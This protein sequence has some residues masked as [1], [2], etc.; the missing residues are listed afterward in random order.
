MT[1][2]LLT[3]AHKELGLE[4]TPGQAEMLESFEVGGHSTAVWQCGRRGGKST[5]ADVLALFDVY[6]RDDLRQHLR[7]GEP[8]I[9]AVI[10]PRLEQ[11]QDHIRSC[12]GLVRGNPRLQRLLVSETADELVFSNG[13]KIVAYPCSNRTI[14]GAAWSSVILDE[15]AYFQDSTDGPQAGQRV[16]EAAVPALAQFGDGGWL[17]AL[18]TPRWRSGAFHA[19]V[20]RASSGDFAD[21]HYRHLSTEEMNP[22]ISVDWLAKQRLEDPDLFAREFL[23]EFV[24]GLGSY[25]TSEDVLGCVREGGNLPPVDDVRYVGALDPA[26]SHDAFALSIGHRDV[27]T[28]SAIIDG[29]WSWTRGGHEATLDAIAE[30]ADAYGVSRLRTDQHAAVPVREGLGQRG[31]DTDYRPWSNESKMTAFSRLKVSV[32]TRAVSLPDNPVLVAELLSL[33]ARPTP[34]GMTRIAAA[35]GGHDDRAIVVAAVVDLLAVREGAVIVGPWVGERANDGIDGD[36]TRWI[37]K[38]AIRD[39][40]TPVEADPSAKTGGKPRTITPLPW[41]GTA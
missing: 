39:A 28:G 16:L 5:L 20:Q 15:L 10:S 30:L 26:Y 24:D 19:L 14:R 18:S 21:Y 29:V 32:N 31:L 2:Q 35:P 12:A 4:L 3:F 22:R 33:E 37:S 38:A 8:R 1:S 7:P 41:T 17:I 6:L 27:A 13:S 34:G 23:A 40:T 9:T 36:Y 11:A 25:L